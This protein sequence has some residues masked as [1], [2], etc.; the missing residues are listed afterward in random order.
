MSID[1]ELAHEC[2]LFVFQV[3][4]FYSCFENVIPDTKLY[5]MLIIVLY[6]DYFYL[7]CVDKCYVGFPYGKW[8]F[9][10]EHKFMFLN[11]LVKFMLKKKKNLEVI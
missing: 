9:Y 8:K 6:R 3:A 1:M 4:T 5:Y 7:K 10:H 11:N 2:D